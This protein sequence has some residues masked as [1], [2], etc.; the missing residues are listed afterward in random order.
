[1]GKRGATPAG[2]AWKRFRGAGTKSKVNTIVSVLRDTNLVSEVPETARCMLAEGAT[3]ALSTAVEQRHKFQTEMF[4]LIGETLQSMARRLQGKV[5]E[6]RNVVEQ[7]SSEMEHKKEEHSTAERVLVEAKDALNQALMDSKTAK[8][9][10]NEVEQV[11]A[12]LESEGVS[13]KRRRDQIAKEQAKFTD[14]MDNMLKVLL[15]KGSEAGGSEKNAKKLSEKLMKQIQHLG[16]EP[17][18]LA[19]APSVLLKKPEERQGFDS[20]VV[21][22]VQALVQDRLDS[23]K[24]N[25]DE[26]DAKEKER[27]PQLTAQSEEV[28]Q[29]QA[30]C[31]E[32]KAKLE[33]AEE[34]AC[35]KE[36]AVVSLKTVLDDSDKMAKEKSQKIEMAEADVLLFEEV[37]GIFKD[38]EERSNDATKTVELVEHLAP[39]EAQTVS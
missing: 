34:V 28:K 30:R 7:F 35:D 24:K 13:L 39:A 36:V 8:T 25:L 33:A 37:L 1:M 26:V 17:A 19:S 21:D 15:E 38:L 12:S 31:E 16:G 3:A 9:A 18:L 22:S 23:I 10:L 5:D 2:A 29:A 14:I 6:A 32:M 20:H 27:E 4:G 11:M